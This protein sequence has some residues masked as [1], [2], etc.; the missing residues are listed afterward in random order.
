MFCSTAQRGE[1]RKGKLVA[2]QESNLRLTLYHD[3]S[4][5]K[6]L[7]LAATICCS[8]NFHASSLDPPLVHSAVIMRGSNT[9]THLASPIIHLA[10]PIIHLASPITH[11][12]SHNFLQ[13]TICCHGNGIHDVSCSNSVTACV[14]TWYVVIPVGKVTMSLPLFSFAVHLF[15]QQTHFWREAIPQIVQVAMDARLLMT[16]YFEQHLEEPLKGLKEEW[17]LKDLPPV[18]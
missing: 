4:V 16:V 1:E 10:S 11:L 6:P 8:R 12:A 14:L 13:K 2:S 17:N 3:V 5:A 7:I 15:S 9:H 18:A